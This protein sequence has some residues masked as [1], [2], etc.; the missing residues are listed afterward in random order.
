MPR[1]P[2]PLPRLRIRSSLRL[3]N[4][5]EGL[6]ELSGNPIRVSTLQQLTACRGRLLSRSPHRGTAVHA[7][8]FIRE[9]RILIEA[10]L[11]RDPRQF[12]L[13]LIHELF[14]F[15]WARLSNGKRAAF[16]GLLATEFGAGARG[17]MGESA[18]LKK[19]ARPLPGSAAWRDYVCESFCD[20]AATVYSGF[21]THP[22]FTLAQRWSSRRRAWFEQTFSLPHR[23]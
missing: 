1:L 19:C 12:R 23:C 17:E 5:L 9:R 14:H 2:R 22:A 13:I 7:A 18:E 8:S 20:T 16:A 6:P 3:G 15:V 21:E 4:A 10:Q 11:V